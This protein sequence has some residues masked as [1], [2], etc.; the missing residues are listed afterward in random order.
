MNKSSCLRLVALALVL[1]LLPPALA[2]CLNRRLSADP[3]H[4]CEYMA[5]KMKVKGPDGRL[6][7]AHYDP[8]TI[9]RPSEDQIK[10]VE[11][12]DEGELV[13]R[14]QWSDVL[15][16]IRG[17]SED[18]DPTSIPT[19]VLIY[20]H[21]WKHDASVDDEDLASFR[22][23]VETLRRNIRET[24]NVIGLFVAW[25]GLSGFTTLDQN[26][27][28]WSRKGAADRVSIGGHLSK[29]LS[30]INSVRCQRNNSNDLVIAIGHSFGARILFSATSPI[31]LNEMQMSHP[32]RR[33]GKFAPFSGVADLTVLLNP[34]FEA[35]RYSAINSSRR[36]QEQFD[37]NQQPVLLSVSTSNDLATKTAFPLGQMLGSRWHSRE[38]E[39][40]GN[41]S[42]FVT[43][44]LRP[45]KLEHVTN[46]EPK[47]WYDAFCHSDIC[48][49]RNLRDA[50]QGNPFVV[51]QTDKSVVDGHNGIW[52]PHFNQWLTA[53]ILRTRQ[54]LMDKNVGHGICTRSP[55]AIRK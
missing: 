16:E 1:A 32:G 18:K 12:T 13:D 50:D 29:L 3:K 37:K 43:H 46:L 17:A 8:E 5:G 27:T 53:F 38:R 41:Y 24:T 52:G 54:G 39:T 21:G 7:D 2:G 31:L 48:L 40:I 51:A 26:L 44:S 19:F 55:P 30:S 9:S 28:F 4:E 47:W 11:F 14:C 15:Y 25:P 45:S 35:S 22:T 20:I 34:A 10:L 42:D 33:G 23:M 6:I 49:T 36:W